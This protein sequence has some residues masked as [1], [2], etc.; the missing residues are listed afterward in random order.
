MKVRTRPLLLVAALL[1]GTVVPL[2]APAAAD[3]GPVPLGTKGFADI[4]VDEAHGRMFVSGGP[5]GPGVTVT[6][7]EGRV[8][9]TLAFTGATGLALSP[10]G[11]RLWMAQPGLGLASIDPATLVAQ[12]RWQLDGCPGD[13]AVVGDRLV[14]GYSCDRYSPSGGGSGGIGVL[15]A[16]TGT[17]YGTVTSGPS[18]KPVVA[19]G[20]AGQVYAADAG[21]S[22]TDLYLFDVTGSQATLVAA[23]DSVCSNLRDLSASPDGDRVVTSCGNPYRHDVWSASTLETLPAYAADPYP[24]AG[25]FSADGHTFAGGVDASYSTDVRV[26]SADATTPSRTYDFGED[27]LL[28][29]RGLALSADG[30]RVWAVTRT[31]WG[32]AELRVLG[33]TPTPT[34]TPVRSPATLTLASDPP[35]F[36]VGEKTGLGGWLSSGGADIAGASL[37]VTRTATGAAPIALPGLTT[38]ADGT[39]WFTDS[40][41]E[42]GS[43]TYTVTWAKGDPR[44]CERHGVGDRAPARQDPRAARGAVVE[45]ARGGLRHHP[46]ALLRHGRADGADGADSAADPA[47]RRHHDH[48]GAGAS[49]HGPVGRC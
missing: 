42:P 31:N 15:G 41:S 36:F 26:Y 5:S 45:R 39:Y 44:R 1:A 18:S 21:L 13:V 17:S 19:T 29:P 27:V 3:T 4:V 10:D 25:A 32:P 14:Y 35:S 33:G 6:D 7:L 43:Y 40:P 2:T 24:L 22:P 28:Q 30:S 46:A 49:H 34:P 37:T 48:D 12:E 47:R 20:P 23:R 9:T 8:V 16:A 38:R 11:S